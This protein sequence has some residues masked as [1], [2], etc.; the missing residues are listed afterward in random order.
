MKEHELDA[1][2]RQLAKRVKRHAALGRGQKSRSPKRLREEILE[3][4]LACRASGESLAAIARR[5]GMVQSTLARWLRQHYEKSE[6]QQGFRSVAIVPSA[7]IQRTPCKPQLRVITAAG[8]IIEGLDL[9]SVAY[10]LKAI[11]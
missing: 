5:L 11:Q 4:A 10:L 1:M 7:E 8:H 9:E 2:C 3:Y 6:V